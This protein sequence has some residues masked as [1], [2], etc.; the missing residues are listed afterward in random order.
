MILSDQYIAGLFDGEGSVSLQCGV[1]KDRK[2]HDY[3]YCYPAVRIANS[4]RRVLELVRGRFGGTIQTYEIRPPRRQNYSLH[5][6]AGRGRVFLE[7]I[8]P[9]LIIKRTVAWIVFCFLEKGMRGK[10]VKGKQGFPHLIL[11]DIE[12]REATRDLV[13]KMNANKGLKVRVSSSRDSNYSR[14]LSRARPK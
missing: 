4:N 3:H 7:T 12:L 10:A 2:G 8:T 14:M 1:R 5:M 11:S 9:Y 6:G 13:V